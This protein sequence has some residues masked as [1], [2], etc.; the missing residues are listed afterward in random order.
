MTRRAALDAE[1]D[2]LYA[3][4]TT[5]ELRLVEADDENAADLEDQICRLELAIEDLEAD[6]AR[7]EEAELRSDYYA[8]R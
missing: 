4:V 3:E 8:G 5:L 7:A 6:A 2:R 1:I